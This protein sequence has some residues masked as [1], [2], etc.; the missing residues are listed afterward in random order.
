MWLTKYPGYTAE[1]FKPF[2]EFAREYTQQEE[3][4]PSSDDL[5]ENAKRIREQIEGK[6]Q[7]EYVKT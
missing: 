2:S 7:N 6:T 1:T 3:P 4:P 5:L